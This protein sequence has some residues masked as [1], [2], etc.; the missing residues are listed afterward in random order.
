MRGV[1]TW[2]SCGWVAG[3]LWLGGCAVTEPEPRDIDRVRAAVAEDSAVPI[4]QLSRE[5]G[6]SDVAVIAA[7]PEAMRRQVP[8]DETAA[9]LAEMAG[10]GEVELHFE[11]IGHAMVYRG[12]M[13][14]VTR[15]TTKV[16]E[17]APAGDAG[18]SITLAKR[19]IASVWLLRYP[20][21]DGPTVWFCEELG[22][23]WLIIR[24]QE[25]SPAFDRAWERLD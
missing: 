4:E 8:A 5:L 6:I 16:I 15:E 21:E 7:L 2:A 1:S 10:W 14:R 11:V 24:V 20:E 23:P 3:V 9:L 19:D 22:E 17:L 13:P 18:L 25:K 12:P